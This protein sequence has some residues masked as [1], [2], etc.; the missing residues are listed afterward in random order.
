MIQS[1]P[2]MQSEAVRLRHLEGLP[3]EEIAERLDRS[4]AATAGLIKRGLQKLREKM[5]QESWM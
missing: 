1:L 4:A 2:E 5:S 3:V